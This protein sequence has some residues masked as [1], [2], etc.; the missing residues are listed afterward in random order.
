MRVIATGIVIVVLTG[1]A[2]D[3]TTKETALLDGAWSMVSGEANGFAMPKETVKDG[4][5]VAK[6]G[7][8]IITFAG[9]VYFKAKF[10]L[11]PTKNPKAID[12][13]MTA[14]PTEGKTISREITRSMATR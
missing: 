14:G 12:Y 2:Q 11:D 13:M 7:E 9:N 6:D 8:T 5:R 3:V 1:A 4:K 10:S